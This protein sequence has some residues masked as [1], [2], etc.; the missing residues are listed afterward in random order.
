MMAVLCVLYM[1]LAWYF[2]QVFAGDLGASQRFWFPFDPAYWGWTHREEV[3]PGDT[4]AREQEQSLQ[5]Q[6][7]RLHKLSK[8]YVTVLPKAQRGAPPNPLP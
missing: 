8:A 3:L 5:E 7:I 2:G 6:S 1:T 4:L